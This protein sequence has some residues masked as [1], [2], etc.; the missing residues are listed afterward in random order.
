[1][2][3]FFSSFVQF[4]LFFCIVFSL[5]SYSFLSSFKSRSNKK[6]YNDVTIRIA[7]DNDR[8]R[9]RTKI[10]STMTSHLEERSLRSFPISLSLS[11]F[12]SCSCSCSLLFFFFLSLSLSFAAMFTAP[13][14]IANGTQ[15]I[16]PRK[17]PRWS[18]LVSFS[19]YEDDSTRSRPQTR[20][21][22]ALFCAR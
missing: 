7:A 13:T 14:R 21:S 4:L 17:K 22:P 16:K 11:L 3:N 10:S 18:S 15:G 8:G 19:L 12:H 5:F 20:V 2:Y 9:S 1:M 6:E